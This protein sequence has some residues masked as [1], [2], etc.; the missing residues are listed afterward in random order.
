[1]VKI[2]R[3]PLLIALIG[4]S[5]C[6]LGIGIFPDRLMSYEGYADLSGYIEKDQ[7]WDFDFQ[8]IRDSRPG[9]GNP[10]F[11]VL[12]SDNRNFGGVHVAIFDANLKALGKYT[13]DNLDAMDPADPYTGRGAMVDAAGKIVVGNRRFTVSSR[14]VVYADSISQLWQQGLAVPEGP[15]INIADIRCEGSDLWYRRYTSTWTLP[16]QD[17][18]NVSSVMGAWSKVGGIWHRGTYVLLV[19]FHENMTAHV[20]RIDPIAFASGGITT[21]IVN[22]TDDWPITNSG[23]FTWETLGYTAEGFAVYRN[24]TNQYLRFDELGNPIGTPLNLSEEER[25]Y[26]QRHVYGRTAGWYIFR[27]KEMSLERRAWWWK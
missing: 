20:V 21:P 10:E 16:V 6:N 4:I 26:E 7:V 9:S 5:G 12:S 3:A 11:L 8:I 2:V 25:P 15:D 17:M 24:D 14:A 23:Y 27:P 13:I 18:K 19:L 22:G 1:M